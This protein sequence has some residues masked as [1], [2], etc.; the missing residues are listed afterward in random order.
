MRPLIALVV[1]LTLAGCVG[2]GYS[3]PSRALQGNLDL[4][5]GGANLDGV[6]TTARDGEK[7]MG[8]RD[9]EGGEDMYSTFDGP[10]GK[11]TGKAAEW[12][13]EAVY[14]EKLALVCAVFSGSSM[15]APR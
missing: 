15:C 4:S 3:G 6:H 13:A 7:P 9:G 12:L 5:L 11:A 2:E 8:Y 1:T 14:L 10:S